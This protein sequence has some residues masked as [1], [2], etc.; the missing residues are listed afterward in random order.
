VA[1]RTKAFNDIQGIPTRRSPFSAFTSHASAYP[2]RGLAVST[3]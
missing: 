2:W 1:M 3:E